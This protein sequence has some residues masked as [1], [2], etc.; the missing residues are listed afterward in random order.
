[1]A[2]EPRPKD[3]KEGHDEDEV[4]PTIPASAEDRKTAA[5]LSSLEARSGEED[6][7]RKG[8]VDT[9]AL[10]QAM[11]RLDVKE[12]GANKKEEGE[13]KKVVKLDP[14]DVKLV[15]GR[16]PDLSGVLGKRQCGIVDISECLG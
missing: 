15:V 14:E 3:F 6:G 9:E 12:D 1:M 13:K 11:R 4:P 5:A 10:G 2:E 8:N 7:D 16:P